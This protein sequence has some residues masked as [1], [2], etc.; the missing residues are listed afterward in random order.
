MPGPEGAVSCNNPTP[1]VCPQQDFCGIAGYYDVSGEI[2]LARY[3]L[4]YEICRWRVNLSEFIDESNDDSAAKVTV[5]L[6]DGKAN[7]GIL[8]VYLF[9]PADEKPT[10]YVYS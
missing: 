5:S 9:S 4:S 1:V 6:I 3:L 10:T 8:R 2:F 7:A